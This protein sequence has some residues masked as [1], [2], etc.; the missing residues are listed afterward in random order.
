MLIVCVTLGW[1]VERARKQRDA[2]TWIQKFE[3][4]AVVYDY[5]RDD[6][7]RPVP[8]AEPPGPKW[9]L[10]QLGIDFFADVVYAKLVEATQVSD[11]SPLARLTSLESL[12]LDGA[13]VSDV[14]ALSGLTSLNEL[15]LAY[16][17]VSDVTALS[18]LTSLE[19]LYLDRTPVSDVTA[20]SG[21]T[22]L[23][24]LHLWDTQVSDVTPLDRLTSLEKLDIEGTQVSENA[25][26]NLRR[27]LPQCVI[28]PASTVRKKRL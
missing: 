1:K 26:E 21:L 10:K 8:N 13:Q 4:G 27:A 14:T 7:G 11:V 22:S 5:E 6:N 17:Q 16:T 28:Y 24:M 25:V 20:L 15:S 2:V 12:V 23:K 18:G 9:L 19:E 3:R